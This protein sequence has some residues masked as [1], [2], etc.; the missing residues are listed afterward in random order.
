MNTIS[1]SFVV[2]FVVCWVLVGATEENFG[3]DPF[4]TTRAPTTHAPTTHA[5]TTKSPTTTHAPT[6]PAPTTKAPTTT[7]APTTHAPAT[8]PSHPIGGEL[9]TWPPN[10][11]GGFPEPTLPSHPIGGELPTRPPQHG[12]GGHHSAPFPHIP[13]EYYTAYELANINVTKVL[14]QGLNYPF[15][16]QI[17]DAGVYPAGIFSLNASGRITP[18]G[19]FTDAIGSFEYFYGLASNFVFIEGTFI[20]LIAKQNLVAMRIDLTINLTASGEGVGLLNLTQEGFITFDENSLITSYDLVILNLGEAFDPMITA[21]ALVEIPEEICEVHEYY[22]L[23]ANQQYANF[24]SCLNYIYNINYGTWNNAASNTTVCRE[25]HSLLVPLRPDYHC[26][27][28][29]PSGGG[30]CVDTPYAEFY[31]ESF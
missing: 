1:S 20:K 10:P 30:A 26:P 17:V 13:D 16:A 14:Y 18:V 31:Q 2:L 9:P 29:G 28:I 4:T 23:G 3:G 11:I 5:P 22:C 7:H 24:E 19:S 21:E 6:T 25:L 15:A 8:L 27:H 12:G